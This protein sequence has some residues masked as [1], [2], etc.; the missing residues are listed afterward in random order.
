M[1][2]KP[3]SRLGYENDSR[4]IRIL[5]RRVVAGVPPGVLPGGPPGALQYLSVFREPSLGR[6]Y[7]S[8]A[9][10][11]EPTD[12]LFVVVLQFDLSAIAQHLLVVFVG[13][14][15][16]LLYTSPSPRDRG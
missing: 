8:A 6:P 12:A 3:G 11:I 2:A 10:G 4:L 5:V 14:A 13:L 9:V 7:R 16:C 15:L 1:P